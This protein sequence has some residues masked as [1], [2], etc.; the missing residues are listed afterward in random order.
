MI[1][2]CLVN[3][4]KNEYDKFK[5]PY[6]Y[7][8]EYNSKVDLKLDINKNIL[9]RNNDHVTMNT[10]SMLWHTMAATELRFRRN[11]IFFFLFDR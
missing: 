9:S 8:V 7:T 2:S 5:N 11:S 3:K 4:F 1:N 6:L 10:A